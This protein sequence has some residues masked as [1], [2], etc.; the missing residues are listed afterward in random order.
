LRYACACLCVYARNYVRLCVAVCCGV[1]QCDIEC[2]SALQSVAVCCSVVQCICAQLR[3]RVG[4]SVYVSALHDTKV[5]ATHGNTLQHTATHC[6][7]LH[8]TATHCNT[9]HHTAPHPHP[10]TTI[11]S[12]SPKSKYML[13]KNAHKQ[14]TDTCCATALHVCTTL[15]CVVAVC[16]SVLQCV[17]MNLCVQLPC[18]CVPPYPALFQFGAVW[19]SVLQCVAVC[20]NEFVAKF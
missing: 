11:N 10:C 18:K 4:E 13:P 12:R 2:C 17:A 20:C 9:Q 7:A 19:C 1:L 6:T 8:H 5:I 15:S 14:K 16:C 3:V